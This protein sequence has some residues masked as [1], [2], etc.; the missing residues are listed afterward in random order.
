MV[1]IH[2][3]LS[4]FVNCFSYQEPVLPAALKKAREDAKR[5]G[6]TE[7]STKSDDVYLGV[8]SDGATEVMSTDDAATGRPAIKFIEVGT[9]FMDPKDQMRRMKES[10]RRAKIRS[11]KVPKRR[12]AVA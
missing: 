11:K 1:H 6:R 7:D 5:Y 12:F 10:Q 3:F 9:M 4:L 8:P 2:P